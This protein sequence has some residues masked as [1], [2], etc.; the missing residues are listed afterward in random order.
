MGLVLASWR[1]NSSPMS[2]SRYSII[3]T[4]TT[5]RGQTQESPAAQWVDPT[6]QSDGIDPTSI[7]SARDLLILKP[8]DSPYAFQT[9]VG[10]P[11]WEPCSLLMLINQPLHE[12]NQPRS[13]M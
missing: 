9:R 12:L 8:N 1:G 10:A 4:V 2:V 3:K 6:V 13:A 11:R 7:R 5:R